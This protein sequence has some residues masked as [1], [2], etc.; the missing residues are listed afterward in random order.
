MLNNNRSLTTP[1]QPI[2]KLKLGLDT[3]LFITS[4]CSRLT[5]TT[6]LNPKKLTVFYTSR[7]ACYL[8]W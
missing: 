8:I 5:K 6:V 1:K 3:L 2:D 4:T 7:G